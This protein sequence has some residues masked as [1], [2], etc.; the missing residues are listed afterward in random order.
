[1]DVVSSAD[2]N[3][4]QYLVA[5]RVWKEIRSGVVLLPYR[6]DRVLKLFQDHRLAEG[7]LVQ[8]AH[9]VIRRRNLAPKEELKTSNKLIDYLARLPP[10]DGFPLHPVLEWLEHLAVAYNATSGVTLA[11]QDEVQVV[12]VS[13]GRDVKELK[14]LRESL[15]ADRPTD[16][17][18]PD[19]PLGV[20]VPGVRPDCR[21][22]SVTVSK[23]LR[24][25]LDHPNLTPRLLQ[26]WAKDTLP[27]TV[28]IDG[29][30]LGTSRA[31]FLRGLVSSPHAGVGH[32][33]APGV[34]TS[35]AIDVPVGHRGSARGRV[36]E[37][38]LGTEPI[39]G[40]PALNKDQ[41]ERLRDSLVKLCDL[42][43]KEDVFQTQVESLIKTS[44]A[45]H[46]AVLP[47][48]VV[49]QI[50]QAMIR[51]GIPQ[52]LKR[53]WCG[54]RRLPTAVNR[55]TACGG[56]MSPNGGRRG[57]SSTSPVG[58]LRSPASPPSRGATRACRCG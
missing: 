13:F 10:P 49:E 24:D 43:P 42:L 7:D 45:K 36:R 58:W 41:F 55:A 35:H 19:T 14:E 28:V 18:V 12:W 32:G 27:P 31:A 47:V 23:V 40:T 53:C 39:A 11:L 44:A 4:E 6:R 33:D 17:S 26:W 54:S 8:A 20:A 37:G 15:K 38:A 50:R 25:T 30:D 3:S 52:M 46:P 1:M 5:E 34:G 16:E 56:E 2:S 29:T 51:L 21:S 48:Q 57:S 9:L 22:P